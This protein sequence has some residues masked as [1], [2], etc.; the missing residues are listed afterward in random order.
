VGLPATELGHES[1]DGRSVL[2]LSRQTTENHSCVFSQGPSKTGAIKELDG[3]FVIRWR[4]AGDDLFQ[5]NRELIRI[6]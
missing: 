4:R 2:C 3:V 6:E 1:Q 5:R